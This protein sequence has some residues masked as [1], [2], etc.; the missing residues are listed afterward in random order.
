MVGITWSKVIALFFGLEH[1]LATAT[2]QTLSRS[3][4]ISCQCNLVLLVVQDVVSRALFCHHMSKMINLGNLSDFI[5][6]FV[7]FFAVLGETIASAKMSY[8]RILLC[9]DCFNPCLP[10]AT[11]SV[12]PLSRRVHSFS[13]YNCVRRTGLI[14]VALVVAAGAA[15]LVTFQAF[16]LKQRCTSMGG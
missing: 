13:W 6:S 3:C 15:A 8:S 11:L 2:S 14:V 7:L 9:N 5:K 16:L 12:Q 4:R 1:L 10:T